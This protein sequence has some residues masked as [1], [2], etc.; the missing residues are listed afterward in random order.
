MLA[1]WTGPL[2]TPQVV[3]LCWPSNS[4]SEIGLELTQRW[5]VWRVSREIFMNNDR[6]S[7]RRQKGLLYSST[8]K[9]ALEPSHLNGVIMQYQ[10][11]SSYYCGQLNIWTCCQKSILMLVRDH[12]GSPILSGT[13]PM[14]TT[15]GTRLLC[16]LHVFHVDLRGLCYSA[17]EVLPHSALC[18]CPFLLRNE[19]RYSMKSTGSCLG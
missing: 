19:D 11:L 12:R 17:A 3:I 14:E 8:P 16:F 15:S 5:A 13:M 18:R 2:R 9:C 1:F 7:S 6:S 4:C 10:Q